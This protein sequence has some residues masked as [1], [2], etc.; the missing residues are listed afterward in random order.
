MR[1]RATA[2]EFRPR[3][4]IRR[5]IQQVGECIQGLRPAARCQM[6]VCFQAAPRWGLVADEAAGRDPELRAEEVQRRH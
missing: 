5:A 2:Q 1:F 3:N 4:R 6:N